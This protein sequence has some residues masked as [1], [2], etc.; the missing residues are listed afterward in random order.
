MLN[1]ESY[2][3]LLRRSRHARKMSQRALAEA[4]F[5]D[6]TH[7]SHIERGR[8][9]GSAD[10]AARCDDALGAEGALV[11]AHSARM[12]QR[13]REGQEDDIIRRRTMLQAMSAL[14]MGIGSGAT[15]LEALRQGFSLAV[16]DRR[17]NEWLLI[18]HEYASRYFTV[19]API[20]L[21]ELSSDLTVLQHLLA[22]ETS[23]AG[24]RDLSSAGG[25]LAALMAMSLNNMGQDQSA[26]RWWRSAR[27]ALDASGDEA[28]RLWV[29]GCEATF[30]FRDHPGYAERVISEGLTVGNTPCHG[31]AALLAIRAQLSAQ[32]GDKETAVKTLRTAEK[33]TEVMPTSIANDAVSL[34]GWPALR[35]HHTA[36]HVY[37]YLGMTREAYRVQDE[38]LAAY[39]TELRVERIKV[40][41]HRALCLVHDGDIQGAMT[42]GHA[43]LDALPSPPGASI[44]SFIHDL[45]EAVPPLERKRTDAAE[46]QARLLPIGQSS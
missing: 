2:G 42:Q 18:A 23:D 27:Q 26:S 35:F 46:L 3:L 33:I 17:S 32:K 13:D 40:E 6:K 19:P 21:T 10:L 37:S 4:V 14:A 29:R 11:T 20:L 8:S 30:Y 31:Y 39:P 36:S 25:Q 43:A 5:T 7:I 45:M 38:A 1:D 24:R 9:A 41:L 34:H 16:D 15:G 12:A 28:L 44:S 22:A